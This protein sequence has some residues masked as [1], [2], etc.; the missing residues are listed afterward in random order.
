ML[1]SIC[2]MLRVTAYDKCNTCA[3]RVIVRS[4]SQYAPQWQQQRWRAVTM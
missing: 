1:V 4:F 2:I 3:C